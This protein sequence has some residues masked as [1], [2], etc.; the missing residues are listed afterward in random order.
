MNGCEGDITRDEHFVPRQKYTHD[1]YAAFTIETGD[2]SHN[3]ETGSTEEDPRMM[4]MFDT[5]IEKTKNDW[6]SDTDDDDDDQDNETTY[7]RTILN[8]LFEREISSSDNDQSDTNDN[9]DNSMILNDNNEEISQGFG[10]SLDELRR[11][12][13]ANRTISQQQRSTEG[14]SSSISTQTITIQTTTCPSNSRASANCLDNSRTTAN[15]LDNYE[16]STS[17]LDNSKTSTS[18]LD[19]LKKSTSCFDNSKT[20]TN[21]VDNSKTLTNCLDNFKTFTNCPDSCSTSTTCLDKSRTSTNNQEIHSQRNNETRDE[22]SSNAIASHDMLIPFHHRESP[23]EVNSKTSSACVKNNENDQQDPL[24][25]MNFNTIQNNNLNSCSTE[26][27]EISEALEVRVS[28]TEQCA[29]LLPE[30]STLNLTSDE[31]TTEQDDL[32]ESLFKNSKKTSR[33]RNYRK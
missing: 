30:T 15:C 28:Q 22:F 21:C 3:Y 10:V 6:A 9:E 20:L 29:P 7:N 19:S 18:Y 23:S 32:T 14:E 12:F 8:L 1:Q 24:T 31:K 5:L 13:R 25:S 17:C 27:T 4:A 16:T 2:L 11:I 33:K 26:P